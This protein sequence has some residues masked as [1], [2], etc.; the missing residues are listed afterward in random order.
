MF[1]ASA[2]RR[3]AS[4]LMEFQSFDADYVRRLARGDVETEL[5][6]TRY[7]SQLLRLKLR[8]RLKSAQDVEDA[9]QETLVRVF[10]I[11][12]DGDGV[13][14]PERLGAFV[15]SVCNNV[16]LEKYRAM[17]RHPQV[18]EEEQE[19][20]GHHPDLDAPLVSRA[21][22]KFVVRM[23]A[24]LSEKDRD[25]L[26]KL[27]LEEWDRDR[28]CSELGISPTYLRVLLHRA[29]ARFR[30]IAERFGGLPPGLLLMAWPVACQA[31]WTPSRL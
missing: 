17:Q 24:E 9:S 10:Q 13:R 30:E 29:K 18:D 28:I 8:R 15:N 26:S 12:R 7:F 20:R 21:R 1:G 27:F 31:F 14:R 23:L 2:A 6:F 22:K 19:V 25:L 5:N 3:T 4:K 11:I 16:L